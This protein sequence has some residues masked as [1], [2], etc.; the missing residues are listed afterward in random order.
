MKELSVIVVTHDIDVE[1]F[2]KMLVS[3]RDYTPELAQLIVF[4]NASPVD[5]KP[6]VEDIFKE[7]EIWIS[8]IKS[9]INLG[10]IK[11]CNKALSYVTQEFMATLNDDI[12]LFSPW[13]GQ[14]IDILKFYPKV[15][16]VTPKTGVCN[17]LNKNGDG[18]Y[19]DIDEPDYAEGSCCMTRTALMKEFGFYDEI[20]EFAYHEDADLSLRLR[21]AGYTIRNVEMDW[22]HYGETTSSKMMD[23][24]RKYQNKNRATF[25]N[26]WKDVFKFS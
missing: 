17:F 1:M 9:E 13:A 8:Y 25:N 23:I 7:S 18:E 24:M 3:L 5:H 22:I 4:D 10:Y 12:E 19:G 2:R 6:M 20:Y 11:A 14:M 26:R 15:A 21:Q 16:Q